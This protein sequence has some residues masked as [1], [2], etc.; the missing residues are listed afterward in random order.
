MKAHPR[1]RGEHF[2]DYGAR[3]YIEGSSPLTRGALRP[4]VANGLARR[5]IPAYAGSTAPCSPRGPAGPAHPRLR[6][7]HS[8]PVP[9]CSQ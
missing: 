7:E 9:Y 5:L 8:F 3:R 6:G 4:A 2:G 1:L